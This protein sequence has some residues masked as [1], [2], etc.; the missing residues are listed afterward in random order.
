MDPLISWKNKSFVQI[1]SSIQKNKNDSI[2]TPYNLKNAQPLKHYR[3]EIFNSNNIP[4]N[5]T[6]RLGITIDSINLPMGSLYTNQSISQT[7]PSIL[8][9]NEKEVDQSN[10]LETCDYD[11]IREQNARNRTRTTSIIKKNY[12][13]DTNQYL[14]K[15]GISFQQNQFQYRRDDGSQQGQVLING[16]KTVVTYKPNNGKFAQD[17]AVSASSLT[18]RRKFDTI[19]NNAN[20]YLLPYGQSVANAMQYGISDSIYTFKNKIDVPKCD[21]RKRC[22]K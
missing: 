2:Q 19:S 10:Q 13:V 22:D 16:D 15:K 6:S 17:H 11:K 3:R 14:Q 4:L 18:L 9:I 12:S 7:Y 1:V 20:K 21:T 5:T 8:Y